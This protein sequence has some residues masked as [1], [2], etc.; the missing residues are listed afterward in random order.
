MVGDTHINLHKQ[1][2]DMELE[3][4]EGI[5]SELLEHFR[6]MGGNQLK[7]SSNSDNDN[8]ETTDFGRFDH[9]IDFDLFDDDNGDDDDD[10]E[11]DN[12]LD[13]E[14]EG[15][16]GHDFLAKTNEQLDF[17]EGRY[18]AGRNGVDFIN[19]ETETDADGNVNVDA[20]APDQDSVEIK[21]NLG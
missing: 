11:E 21:R 10:D 1:R 13:E 4:A 18:S 8:E 7:G 3:E 2:E 14:V 19:A 16:E 6:A 9:E 20:V 12:E 5:S 15:N 17:V